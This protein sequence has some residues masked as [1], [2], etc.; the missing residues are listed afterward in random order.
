MEKILK[1]MCKDKNIDNTFRNILLRLIEKRNSFTCEICK[2]LTPNE[3]E[4]SEP[5]TCAMCM[6]LT[7]K[8]FMG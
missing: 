4:G 5:N 3:C 8:E 1:M 6:P 2:C 7:D